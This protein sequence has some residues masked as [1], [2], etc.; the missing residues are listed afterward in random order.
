MVTL[1]PIDDMPNLVI[2]AKKTPFSGDDLRFFCICACL[3]R[4]LQLVL[5]IS[6][7]ACA[8]IQEEHV[9]TVNGNLTLECELDG[10]FSRFA[11]NGV[12]VLYS[13][14]A[15]S[16]CLAILGLGTAIPTI[17]ISMKGTPTDS[18][19]RKALL[20]L[21]YCNISVMNVFRITGFVLAVFATSILQDYCACL[22][23]GMIPSGNTRLREACPDSNTLFTLM[24]ALI[25]THTMD[26]IVA[27]IELLFFLCP[28]KAFPALVPS[29]SK[30]KV[31][32]V[33]FIGCSS[34]LTCCLFGG[35][36]A[37]QGDFGDLAL[38]MSNYTNNNQT[39]D[40]TVS[41]VAAGLIM[42]LRRQR[43]TLLE[44]REL[45]HKSFY[46]SNEEDELHPKEPPQPR[47]F[48]DP[49]QSKTNERRNRTLKRMASTPEMQGYQATIGIS[50]SE[51]EISTRDILLKEHYQEKFFIAEAARFMP[52]A[53]SMYTWMI[54][55]VEHR[56]LGVVRLGYLIL[57]RCACF[58]PSPR[59]K[60]R[61]D[62][63]WEPHMIALQELSGLHAED[64]IF[65]SFKQSI[66][67]LPYMI[68]VDN[69][70]RSI[71]IAIRGTLSMESVLADMAIRPEE[72]SAIGEKHGFDG[73]GK[74]CHRGILKSSEW[75]YAD[76]MK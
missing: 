64:I 69:E 3:F 17:L 7:V 18:E 55:L 33:C 23:G 48:S 71:V 63:P 65:A 36:E 51:I 28:C 68:S 53:Q 34:T 38:V 22:E 54:Y 56:L 11:N 14:G 46:E 45:V 70:W 44:A 49:S 66:V 5:G 2:C 47:R 37:L 29:E 20:A 35:M 31:F 13:Q 59:D 39:L 9:T 75:I 30:W 10:D 50:D 27:M 73:E 1:V 57:R 24:V 60:L 72:L 40:V 16:I 15:V 76:L 58:C 74:Y 42:V 6:L 26:V 61:Y 4:I 21:C 67:A 25:V 32:L 19:P 8:S 12:A 52:L 43:E 62:F 41:D